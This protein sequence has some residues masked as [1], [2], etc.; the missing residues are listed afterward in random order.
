VIYYYICESVVIMKLYKFILYDGV[1]CLLIN[2]N[3]DLEDMDEHY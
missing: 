2:M 3:A 1:L